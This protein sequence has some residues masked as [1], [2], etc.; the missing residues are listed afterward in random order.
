MPGEEHLCASCVDASRVHK[1]VEKM[2][3]K[4]LSRSTWFE[5]NARLV[6]EP[7]TADA[8][9]A[10]TE[11]DAFLFVCRMRWPEDGLPVCPK[12]GNRQ[13]YTITSRQRF[14]CSNPSCYHQFSPVA[15]TMFG[16]VKGGYVGLLQRMSYDGPLRQAVHSTAKTAGDVR[17]RKSANGRNI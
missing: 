17:R 10:M 9:A 13:C 5:S 12:C 6:G 7:P 8:C 4:R 16:N 1:S 3:V 11:R 15:G 14:K 2:L